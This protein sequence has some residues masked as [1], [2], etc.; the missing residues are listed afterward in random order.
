MI[1]IT[2]TIGNLHIKLIAI[3]MGS[4]INISILGG[5]KPHIGAVAL[6]VSRASLSECKEISSSVSLITVT[7][8]K[9]DEVVM[10]VAKRVSKEI[11]STVSVSCGIHKDNITLNEIKSVMDLVEDMTS[12][13]IDKYRKIMS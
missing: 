11:N 8:H 13:F 10:K 9:E 12:E 7:G 2:K 1:E 6:A 5:D 3:L 4:D